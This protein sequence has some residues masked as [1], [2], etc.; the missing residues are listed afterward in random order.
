MKRVLMTGATGFVGANLARRLVN[1]GHETHLLVRPGWSP[2]RIEGI[3]PDVR[4]VEAGLDDLKRLTAIVARIRP[5]W[6]FHL[7]V[8]GAYSHQ[9]GIHQM[10]DTNVVS[11]INLV[12][13]CLRHGFE[14]FINTGS[15]SEYG[16]KDY[17]PSEQAWLEPNS[18]YAVT[19]AAATLYCRH[20]AQ[21]RQVHLSTLRLYSVY[22]PFE[23]PT[24]LL[25]A[26]I[27][28]G[29]EN[30]L[31]PL[32]NPTIARDYVFVDDVVD[33]YIFAAARPGQEIGAVYN[34]GTGIQTSLGELVAS[35]RRILT[36]TAEPIWGSM[37]N[38][39][40]DSATWV[41]D[42]RAIQR[43]LGWQP[44]YDIESGVGAMAAWFRDDPSRLVF[45]RDRMRR[46]D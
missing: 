38:R 3:R 10:I 16:F 36:I 42:S 35:A 24:R 12:E 19:K 23:E 21:A 22:G 26:L 31:P 28:N 33:A 7:A 4:L 15:S 37:A 34:V 46:G 44:R 2:W 39:Q 8:F 5:D 30:Q 40:W 17:A 27:V 11:T 32:V 18:H 9:A 13:A 43:A 6:I 41:A 20:T 1:D 45:Y 25:P 14:A 29:F